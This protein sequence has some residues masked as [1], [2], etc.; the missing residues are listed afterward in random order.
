MSS[1]RERLERLFPRPNRRSSDKPSGDLER[2]ENELLGDDR[3][4]AE[5]ELSLKERLERLVAAASS[6]PRVDRRP[7]P[8]YEPPERTVVELENAVEGVVVE[9]DAGAFFRVERHLPLEHHHG[10]MPLRR[11]T[12]VPPHTYGVLARGEEG[13]ELDLERALFVDTE[14]TGLAGGS[15]TYA[16]LVGLGFVDDGAFVVRQLFMRDYREEPAMLRDLAETIARYEVL[17]SYNGKSFDV[18]LLE[19]RFVLA[20]QPFSFEGRLHFDLLHPARSLWKARFESCRLSELESTLLGLEREMDVPGH[21]IPDIYFRYVRTRDASR[22]PYVFEHNRDDILSLAALTVSA[23]DMLHEDHVPEDPL[24]DFSLARLFE[25]AAQPERS[26]QHYTRAVE[27][28]VTGL[29][30]RRS[31]HGLALI[32]KRREAWDDACAL[33]TELAVEDGVEALHALQELAMHAEHRA[34]AP[35]RALEHCEAA[36]ERLDGGLLLP[37]GARERWRE[38]FQHRRLRLK[39]RLRRLP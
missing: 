31:L 14:T 12:E 29:A 18:P 15:G 9:N 13:V 24:D 34:R 20:R 22:L 3:S 35:E 26:L 8:Q 36:L 32:H 38:G 30:R 17:V 11:L 39:R 28:G 2:L 25:R 10:S 4:R 16:F 33:W 1:T 23:S 6:K 21:L 27:A 19:T 5:G 7:K 37:P